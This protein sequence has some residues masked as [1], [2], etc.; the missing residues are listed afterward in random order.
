[1]AKHSLPPGYQSL[2][3]QGIDITSDPAEN[4]RRIGARPV[5]DEGAR[6]TALA[7][8]AAEGHL[9]PT[10]EGAWARL[11]EAQTSGPVETLDIDVPRTATGGVDLDTLCAQLDQ[12]GLAP[13]DE[14]NESAR[15]SYMLEG[16]TYF[17]PH[18]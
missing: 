1:M 9:D 17:T 12:A 11:D 2:S 7:V 13:L 4:R 10:R 14:E 15:S 8:A 16:N 18:R 5:T 3:Q 6:K